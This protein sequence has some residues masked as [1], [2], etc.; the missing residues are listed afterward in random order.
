MIDYRDF[1]LDL[2]KW[3]E[4]NGRHNLPWRQDF[5]PYKVWVSE[6]MLQQ[7]QVPRVAKDYFPRFI[8]R[9]PTIQDLAKSSWEELYP[10]WRGLGF[11]RR[12]KNML[13]TAQVI[14]QY[15]RGM[16][17]SDVRT[18]VKF[19]GIGPY[20][21]RAIASF[22][23]NKSHPAIDTNVSKIIRIL[24][25][26]KDEEF[27]AQQLIRHSQNPRDWNGAMMDLSTLLREQKDIEA[28][29]EQY[30]PEEIKKQF[31]PVRKKQTTR[32]KQQESSPKK[33]T[34]RKKRIEVGIGCVWKDGKYLI[35]TRP[36]DK[37]FPGMW[38]FPGGK[39]EKG[40]DF[41]RCVKRE[42]QEELGI[43]V[44]VRPHFYKETIHFDHV[45]LVLCF[46]RCQIQQGEPKPLE[47]QKLQWVA[48]QN[49][50][51]VAFL[52]TNQKALEAIKKIRV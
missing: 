42:L 7:T 21:A 29:M 39:R 33:G 27:V 43:E 19:P 1:T 25:S 31:R 14:V 4:K 22:G 28:P 5:D 13:K 17:T 10:Y 46:H 30:F 37:S 52:E 6:I 8:E 3:F 49:F 24:W 50:D 48:P 2:L 35:Q 40:E 9:F 16:F 18:L 47:G 12:G 32:I 26:D 51:K 34:K 23:F 44:S 20:T 15:H 38:E 11:Y 45:D 36:V 41:R